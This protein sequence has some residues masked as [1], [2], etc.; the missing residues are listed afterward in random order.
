[1]LNRK[2]KENKRKEKEGERKTHAH[3][4]YRAATADVTAATDCMA[5]S[6]SGE[7]YSLPARPYVALPVRPSVPRFLPY[8]TPHK[9][10]RQQQQRS[11][12]CIRGKKGG[13]SYNTDVSNQADIGA[14]AAV[15]TRNSQAHTQ[16]DLSHEVDAAAGA[17]RPSR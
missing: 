2:R 5:A 17:S 7:L 11:S 9:S 16:E 4:V 3:C 13:S 8:F 14:A 15:Q 10:R 12:P 1:M 6:F